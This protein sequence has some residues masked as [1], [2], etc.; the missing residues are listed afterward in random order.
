MSGWIIGI[1]PIGVLAFLIVFRPE[2]I[3][4]MFTTPIGWVMLGM[5]AFAYIIGIL[6]MRN[7]VNMEV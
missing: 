3:A 2:F 5:G 7:L 4:P 6:W 1:L